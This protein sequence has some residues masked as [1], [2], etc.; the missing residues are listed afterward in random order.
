MNH[1]KSQEEGRMEDKRISEALELLNEAAK[2]K[3]A[4]LEQ[5]IS[6]KFGDLKSLVE[7]V[8]EKVQHKTR[9]VYHHGKEDFQDLLTEVD[10]SVH[11]NPW[12]YIG[13]AAVVALFFGYLLGRSK[14]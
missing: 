9:D 10:E 14:E 2:S 4:E 11:K 3:K 13:G 6:H 1:P 12:P 8:T 7:G 5:M